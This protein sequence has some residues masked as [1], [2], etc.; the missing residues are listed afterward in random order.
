MTSSEV[1]RVHVSPAADP[2]ASL[3][4]PP[5]SPLDSGGNSTPIRTPSR[6]GSDP[7]HQ[8]D[9][10]DRGPPKWRS[11]GGSDLPRREHLENH[12]AATAAGEEDDDDSLDGADAT[13]LELDPVE[14]SSWTGQPSIRGSTETMRMILLAFSNIG[15]T[16]VEPDRVPLSR[17]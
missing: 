12:R 11:D 5:H 7:E 9:S 10:P 13:V 3:L 8:Y 15:I 1:S 17:R 14:M 16:Y 6:S 4:P 2:D